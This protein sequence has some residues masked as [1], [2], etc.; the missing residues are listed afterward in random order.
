MSFKKPQPISYACGFPAGDPGKQTEENRRAH[1]F[2]QKGVQ[3]DTPKNREYVIQSIKPK[4]MEVAQGLFGVWTTTNDKLAEMGI[5]DFKES[6]TDADIVISVKEKH[7]ESKSN[8][9]GPSVSATASLGKAGASCGASG[10][11][12][13][14]YAGAKA[15]GAEAS[16]KAAL[17]DGYVE[18]K[19]SVEAASAQASASLSPFGA[20][21]GAHLK[22]AG[23]NAD[24]THTPL[25]VSASVL[26]AGA[27]IGAGWEYTGASVGAHLV[28][29]RA[30]PLG[31]RAG[32]KFGAGV[33]NGVPEVDM[34]PI[35][36]CLM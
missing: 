31:A 17:I 35:S 19:A 3:L 28:E 30:G 5:P 29:A 24:I 20:H 14:A 11:G 2:F 21:A 13:Y 4:R 15:V 10:T 8:L 16:A 25:Q 22:V 9:F 7:R 6:K 34:G 26:G 32:V 27:E 18:A 12:G 23:V 1:Q 36:C 33:R